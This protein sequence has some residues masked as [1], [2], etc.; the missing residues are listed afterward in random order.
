MLLMVLIVL[1]AA[2]A[3]GGAAA[4]DLNAW[5]SRTLCSIPKGGLTTSAASTTVPPPL[6]V[7]LVAGVA[8]V[9]LELVARD[10]SGR[11]RAN[12]GDSFAMRL[13][14]GPERVHAEV[15]DLCNGTYTI[16][17]DLAAPGT[18]V[19]GAFLEWTNN[20]ALDERLDPVGRLNSLNAPLGCA[21]ALK[22]RR[23][24]TPRGKVVGERKCQGKLAVTVRAPAAG[25]APTAWPL[26]VGWNH[27][28]RYRGL[29]ESVGA[30]GIGN[31]LGADHGQFLWGV[32][33]NTVLNVS[34]ADR[35]TP[36]GCTYPA[37]P[38]H[39]AVRRALRGKTVVVAGDSEI[40]IFFINFLQ[41]ALGVHVV[42]CTTPPARCLCHAAFEVRL[43]VGN[44]HP[45][46]KTMLQCH[47]SHEALQAQLTK[48][49]VVIAPPRHADE[50][51]LVFLFAPLYDCKTYLEHD[52]SKLFDISACVQS[53]GSFSAEKALLDHFAPRADVIL[54][55]I[56]LHP[57]SSDRRETQHA[58]SPD[59]AISAKNDAEND[60]EG[61]VRG[62]LRPHRFRRD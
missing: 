47:E 18:Y 32:D 61:K 7:S 34:W 19:W 10:S 11:P 57:I 13:V 48:N 6:S 46:P 56:G 24:R 8:R 23:L 55:D 29:P 31:M 35:W 50:V 16:A 40:R 26:C 58:F 12:G 33:P 15:R 44:G 20:H 37:F 38:G 22:M 27:P 5:R 41:I 17:V 4:S 2:T 42:G 36:T 9:R 62:S 53:S 25:S 1:A 43:D 39:A 45:P 49:G 3:P 14:S 59:R 51:V 60:A 30:H 54:F 28:G 52:S 21:D